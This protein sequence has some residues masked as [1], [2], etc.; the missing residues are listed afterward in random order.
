[1]YTILVKDSNELLGTN[2]ERIKIYLD[3]KSKLS[4]RAEKEKSSSAINQA[5]K[6]DTD[7]ASCKVNKKQYFPQGHTALWSVIPALSFKWLLS[8][9]LGNYS[10]KS[11]TVKRVS[12]FILKANF[13]GRLLSNVQCITLQCSIPLLEQKLVC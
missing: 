1:M 9:S 5:V 8:S 7:K 4:A 10:L 11:E 3:W 12:N 6:T 2:V 13:R